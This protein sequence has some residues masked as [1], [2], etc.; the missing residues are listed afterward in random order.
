MVAIHSILRHVT[1]VGNAYVHA[2]TFDHALVCS[3]NAKEVLSA[4]QTL[5]AFS[6][7]LINFW[8]IRSSCVVYYFV[9]VIAEAITVYQ[10]L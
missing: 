4:K 10:F 1:T 2:F 7:N 9:K 5:K 6:I 8:D 3:Y